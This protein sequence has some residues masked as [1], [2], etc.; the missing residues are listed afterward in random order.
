MPTMPSLPIKRVFQ[1]TPFSHSGIDYFGPLF[2]KSKMETIK[3][4][5][6]LYT[7]LATRAVHLELMFK[8]STDNFS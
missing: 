5:V 4:W 6:C 7:C 2:I 8:M 3:V 1:S